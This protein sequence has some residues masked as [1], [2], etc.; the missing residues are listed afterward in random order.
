M[1]ISKYSFTSVDIIYWI[2]Q[3]CVAAVIAITEEERPGANFRSGLFDR[4]IICGLV[5]R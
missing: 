4:E 1:L 3:G 5:L 2:S